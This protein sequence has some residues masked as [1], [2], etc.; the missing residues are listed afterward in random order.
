MT[1][2]PWS[3]LLTESTRVETMKTTSRR[4]R[5]EVPAANWALDRMMTSSLPSEVNYQPIVSFQTNNEK[6]ITY[7]SK[8][9][10]EVILPQIIF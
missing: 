3:R 1:F 7:G 9:H 5:T 6:P 4:S 10:S 2:D 8:Y